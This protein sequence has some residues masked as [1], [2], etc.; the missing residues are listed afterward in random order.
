[1]HEFCNE[2]IGFYSCIRGKIL[3][4]MTNKIIYIALIFSSLQ[5]FSQNIIY[6]N[7]GKKAEVQYTSSE[8][9]FIYAKSIDKDKIHEIR[10]PIAIID[11]FKCDNA[12]FVRKV[13]ADSPDMKG[14]FIITPTYANYLKN[15]ILFDNNFQAKA[16]SASAFDSKLAG[17]QLSKG[18]KFI[19]I[20]LGLQVLSGILMGVA[21]SANTVPERQQITT[22]ALLSAAG[23][24][25]CQFFGAIQISKAGKTMVGME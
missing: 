3:K 1:M 17:K 5:T 8:P 24:L 9:G 12:K 10:F 11:S 21:L 20:G 6:L 4:Y 14:K 22:I 16:N 18:G 7:T 19:Y 23:G 2:S 25:G 15:E 13:F